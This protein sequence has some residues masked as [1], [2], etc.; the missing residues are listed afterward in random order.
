MD[1]LVA[2][3]N[4]LLKA[5]RHEEFTHME[6]RKEFVQIDQNDLF[7]YLLCNIGSG[8][9]MIKVDGVH[10]ILQLHLSVIC[11]VVARKLRNHKVEGSLGIFN[12]KT[13]RFLLVFYM[14]YGKGQVETPS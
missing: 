11:L 12:A 14:A 2:G 13:T 5:I 1:C 3:A 9:S 4:F 7:P 10:K 6:G 8:V